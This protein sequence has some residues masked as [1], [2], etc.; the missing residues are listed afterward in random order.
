LA[1]YATSTTTENRGHSSGLIFLAANL[2]AI[3][4]A[5]AT[6]SLGLTTGSI[7]TAVWRALGLAIL[8]PANP[9]KIIVEVK[10][11]ISFPKILRDRSLVLYLVPWL[12]FSLIDRSETPILTRFFGE[13]FL[14]SISIL[15]LVIGAFSALLGGILADRIGRKRIV[16]YGYIALG[17]AYAS[18]GIAPSPHISISWYF[19]SIVDSIAAG[20]LWVTCVLILWGDLAPQNAREEYYAIGNLPLFLAG[21]MPPLLASYLTLVPASAAF[22]LASFFL[23][24]AVLPLMYAQETLPERKMEIRKLRNYIDQAE[25][26]KKKIS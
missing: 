13:D 18:I 9:S 17:L 6:M 16:I 22:S 5:L 21:I 23:F 1:Y 12:M 19:Y 7:I 14:S 8:L 10:S 3:L 15:K 24:V 11:K 25:K 2:G 4:A 20:I 26:V